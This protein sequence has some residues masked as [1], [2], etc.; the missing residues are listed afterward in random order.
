MI[1]SFLARRT[2]K[3]S[4]ARPEELREARSQEGTRRFIVLERFLACRL[5]NV[6]SSPQLCHAAA[7]PNELHC[8]K[9]PCP[10]QKAQMNIKIRSEAVD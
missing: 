2:A 1:A 9:D 3:R 6:K 8:G 4:S 10:G 5:L 7:L